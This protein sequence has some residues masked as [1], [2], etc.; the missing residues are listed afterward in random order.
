MSHDSSKEVPFPDPADPDATLA[1][2]GRTVRLPGLEQPGHVIGRYRL[3]EPLGQG[4]FGS[5]WRA[6]QHEPIHREVALKVI[7]A[8]MDSVEIIARFEAERQA[9]ALMDHPNIAAVL[10]AG[11]T[12]NGRPFFVMELVNGVPMTHYCDE[13]HLSIRQRIELFIPVCQAVQHA[14]QK[15]I[16]HRDLKPSNILVT[17]VDGK[18]VPKVIDFG[19]AKALDHTS[20]P[21]LHAELAQTIEGMVVGTPQYM[22]PE[23]AGSM[24]DVD[25]RSDI[26]TLGVILYELL[27]GEPPLG[28]EQLR[29]AAFDEVLR[30]IREGEA[31]RPSS[32]F[33]PV[34]D[35]A[36][37]TADLRNS[38]PKRLGEALRGDLDWIVMRTIEKDRSRRYETANALALDLGRYLKDEPV[39]AG[40]PSVSYRLRKFVRRQ[41]GIL[42]AAAVVFLV[43]I[44]GVV[45]SL[46]QARVARREA[47]RASNAE[48]VAEQRR[49]AAERAQVVADL[50][51][52]TAEDRAETIRRNL[53]VAEMNLAGQAAAQ[54]TGFA[55]TLDLIAKWKPRS[56]EQ[57]LRGWE[58]HYLDSLGRQ[59][60]AT[61]ETHK[62]EVTA[63]AWSPA[64]RVIASC[65][66]DRLIHLWNPST[67]EIIHT[68]TGHEGWVNS[69]DWS[70]DGRFLASGDEL[71]AVKIWDENTGKE[72][73]RLAGHDGA[74][75]AVAWSPDGKFL[76]SGGKGGKLELIV[77]NLVNQS[78]VFR[79]TT[80]QVKNHGMIAWSPDSQKITIC[81]NRQLPVWDARTGAVLQE[82]LVE[83]DS[84]S[85]DWSPTGESLA[86]GLRSGTVV[87]LDVESGL[88]TTRWVGDKFR[89]NA[90]AW[91]PAGTQIAVA[92]ETNVILFDAEGERTRT[93]L[94]GHRDVVTALAW[95]PDGGKFASSSFDGTVKIWDANRRA[96][97]FEE[98]DSEVQT[99]A[100]SP[101]DRWIASGSADHSVRIWDSAT[102]ME[103]AVLRGHPGIV[104]GIAWSYDGR[105]LASAGQDG[106]VKVWDPRTGLEIA[107]INADD[108]GLL[109]VAFS[110][111]GSKLAT[112][113][114]FDAQ[115]CVWNSATLELVNEFPSPHKGFQTVDSISW[116]LDGR[117]LIS[118]THGR[119]MRWNLSSNLGERLLPDSEQ[120]TTA[121]ISADGA[122]CAIGEQK[123][124]ITI[125][126]MSSLEAHS[127]MNSY[128][129][130]SSLDWSPDGTRLASASNDQLIRVWDTRTGDLLLSLPGH[131]RTVTS[132]AWSHDGT[133]I[134]SAG[135]DLTIRIWDACKSYELNQRQ[136]QRNEGNDRAN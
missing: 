94:L 52:R 89:A 93:A 11:T 20:E 79:T 12:E 130:V 87:I 121:A 80:R 76:A 66:R 132:V 43:L 67:R 81:G 78:V 35:L 58:W 23:Q 83:D 117:K 7:K 74:V 75:G 109:C 47:A 111:D 37:M 13:H 133:R 120:A 29:Q 91:N 135:R 85:V 50:A 30:L 26:Y 77:W 61:L 31:R 125:M 33:N 100:W 106:F 110:P 62:R 4:G 96:D 57:D 54:P 56:G 123:G 44:V 116:T 113:Q 34:S 42:S 136:L 134:A 5:V 39:L 40:P 8:G 101:D 90:L 105:R 103:V 59:Q 114:K 95:S 69:I 45:V 1:M 129:W 64:G 6:E 73:F 63:V 68:L 9:L 127:V 36:R 60:E 25:T 38:E 112:G 19:I 88:S 92:C 3:I 53:Y 65:D 128:S 115:I 15:A 86:V 97:V 108:R 119:V 124:R 72:H 16:L 99:V 55:Q 21:A 70:V 49:E 28:R 14:H 126:D 2:D 48:Q 84:T 10:D 71:G 32:R 107:S 118:A 82:F 46:W 27:A 104:K 22:S 41:K 17:E 131:S 18:A 51:T 98:Q 122:L 24:R 102:G